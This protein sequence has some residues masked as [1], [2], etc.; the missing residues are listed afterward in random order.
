MM[1]TDYI[2]SKKLI[3]GYICTT[4]IN[5]NHDTIETCKVTNMFPIGKLFIWRQVYIGYRSKSTFTGMFDRQY[6]EEKFRV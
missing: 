6:Y 3:T 5:G 2:R 4:Y 1:N